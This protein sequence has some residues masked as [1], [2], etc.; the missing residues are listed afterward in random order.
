MTTEP[1]TVNVLLVDD[2]AVDARAVQRAFREHKIGNPLFRARDGL[3]ALD[4]LRGANGADP[5]PGPRMVLLDL[6]MPRM[7]GIEF[8]KELREDPELGGTVVFVL[9][10]S[11][12]DEDR[13]AAYKEHIAGYIV[14]SDV[15]ERFLSLVRLLD[16]YWR[17][18]AL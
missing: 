9:T 4:M 11:E 1:R 17:V 12:A 10:T 7:G 8:L 2:D 18:V 15:G 13:A 6:N 5:V 16:A 3:E 14:K